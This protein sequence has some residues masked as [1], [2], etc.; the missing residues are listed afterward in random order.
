M[1][2]YIYRGSAM[3]DYTMVVVIFSRR[4][5]FKERASYE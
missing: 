5:V 4:S 2:D 1:N 3:N